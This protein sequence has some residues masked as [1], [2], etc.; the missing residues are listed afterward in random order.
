MNL[1]NER[2]RHSIALLRNT[3]LAT[4]FGFGAYCAESAYP[5][6]LLT[7]NIEMVTCPLYV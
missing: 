1:V 5:L 4:G 3:Q 7:P 2:L 6:A